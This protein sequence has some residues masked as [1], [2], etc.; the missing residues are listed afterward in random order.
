MVDTVSPRQA[1]V[2]LVSGQAVLIDVREPDE[3]AASHI[4]YAL[5]AP[6][7]R[8]AAILRDMDLP[9]DLSLIHI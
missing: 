5:S 1:M 9:A 4:P 7:A 3:F 8:T 2:L 6:L